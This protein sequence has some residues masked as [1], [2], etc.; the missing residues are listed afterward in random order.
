MSPLILYALFAGGFGW[1]I[2]KKKWG[3]TAFLAAM[4]IWM[5]INQIAIA[6]SMRPVAF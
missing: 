1:S 4:L 5:M 2:H 6:I 3:L